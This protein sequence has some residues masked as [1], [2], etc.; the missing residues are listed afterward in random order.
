MEGLGIEM[1]RIRTFVLV[2]V[3]LLLLTGC[4]RRFE[5]DTDGYG[6]TD[7]R[8]DIHYTVLDSCYEAA[9]VGEELGTYTDK[10]Y[11]YTLQFYEIPELDSERFV[12][13]NQRQV[14]CADDT[15]PDAAEWEIKELLIWDEDA[16]SALVARVSDADDIAA[17]TALWFEGEEAELPMSKHL[18]FHRITLSCEEYPNIYY[19]FRFY[20]YEEGCYLYDMESRRTVACTDAVIALL[21][22]GV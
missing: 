15:L 16:I 13:D 9:S 22:K 12:T 20:V 2:L 14:Y 3:P 5:R 10:K 4:T 11:D 6:Y 8:T 18:R 19:C 21:D 1:K 17:V 7:A